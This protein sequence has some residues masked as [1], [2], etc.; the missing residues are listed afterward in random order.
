MKRVLIAG[1]GDVGQR[2][3][4]MLLSQ[5]DEVIGVSRS[6][7]QDEGLRNHWVS[8]DLTDDA[9]Y[10]RLPRQVD[11]IVYLPTPSE[12][13]EAGYRAIFVE[14]QQ[15]LHRYYQAVDPMWLFVSSSS[16]YS[17][18]A[19][20]WVDEC[21]PVQ[22]AKPTSRQLLSA[23]N[24]VQQV[25]KQHCVVRFSGLYGPGRY[26]LL[27]SVLS[28]RPVRQ[29]PDY[30]TNRIH[31]HD[32]ARMLA[33]LI[34]R[35]AAGL[36]LDACYLGVDDSPVSEFDVRQWLAQQFQI[37]MGPLLTAHDD[38]Q[39]KRCR[40]DRIRATGFEFTYPTYQRGY[41]AVM[42]AFLEDGVDL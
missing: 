33:H 38:G 28:Q 5:G 14:A 41:A 8:V 31:T 22:P 11:V 2:L 40:N 29:Y 15:R 37:E 17:Q 42:K 21:S 3:A 39:N 36:V 23:E 34:E 9:H 18:C 25:V 12:R 10:S 13:T 19:G 35:Y 27:R 30:F 20:E 26:W 1:F 24:W 16:V 4:T 32:A 6:E 7:P